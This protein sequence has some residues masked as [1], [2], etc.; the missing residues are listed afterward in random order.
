M[1]CGWLLQL[2]RESQS[3]G[4]VRCEELDEVRDLE[5]LSR[6][7]VVAQFG[8]RDGLRSRFRMKGMYA[9]LHAVESRLNRLLVAGLGLVLDLDLYYP[10]M[11]TERR[12]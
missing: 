11:S 6:L 7:G 4:D 9:Y 2:R 5:D 10:G 8:V 12:C 1:V 3:V